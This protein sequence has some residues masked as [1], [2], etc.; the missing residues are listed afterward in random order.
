MAAMKSPFRRPRP[1]ITLEL[2]SVM[3]IVLVISLVLVTTASSNFLRDT[4][5]ELVRD[6][7]RVA[8]EINDQS[9]AALELQGEVNHEIVLQDRAAQLGKSFDEIASMVNL[10]AFSAERLLEHPE[11]ATDVALVSSVD[12]RDKAKRAWDFGP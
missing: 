10:L 9:V 12:F 5:E 6:Q 3:T 11:A 4:G 7:D 8:K 1:S 2:F